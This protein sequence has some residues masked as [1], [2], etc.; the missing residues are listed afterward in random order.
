[1]WIDAPAEFSIGET[2]IGLSL[3]VPT[4]TVGPPTGGA[5][6]RTFPSPPGTPAPQP[7]TRISGAGPIAGGDVD[8]RAGRDAAGRDI[9]H[10]GFKLRT[11]MRRSAKNCIRFGIV[12]FFVG[13]ASLGYF[14][15]TWNSRIFDVVGGPLSTTPPDL[16][17]PLPWLPLGAGTMFLGLVLVITGRLIPRD[18]IVERRDD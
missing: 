7:G 11:R 17:S 12:S 14:V 4:S 5:A 18:Q 6:T 10:E 3:Q 1:M 13:F 9:I 15:V 16:P 8:I 2:T